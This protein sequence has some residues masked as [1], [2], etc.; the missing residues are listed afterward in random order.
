MDDLLLLLKPCCSCGCSAARERLAVQG[1]SDGRGAL[2][3]AKGCL[4][5]LHSALMGERPPGI[6]LLGDMTLLCSDM[7]PDTAAAA[8]FTGLLLIAMPL[9]W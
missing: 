9:A 5:G 4:L 2:H 1:E 6:D 7:M 3:G 8:A